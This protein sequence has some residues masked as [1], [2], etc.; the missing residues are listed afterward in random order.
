MIL[1]LSKSM[2]KR[3]AA[4]HRQGHKLDTTL[5]NQCAYYPR[6]GCQHCHFDSP[7]SDCKWAHILKDTRINP[8]NISNQIKP[9]KRI[10]KADLDV[11]LSRLPEEAREEIMRFIRSWKE[12]KEN[13]S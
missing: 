5:L 10:K 7:S 3:V 4:W 1:N 9:N 6:G 8:P 12:V 13:D 11:L 2:Q